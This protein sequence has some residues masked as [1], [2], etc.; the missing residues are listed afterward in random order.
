MDRSR[1]DTVGEPRVRTTGSATAMAAAGAAAVALAF[2]SGAMPVQAAAA[3]AAW[4]VKPVRLVVGQ[5]IGSALDNAVRVIAPALGEALGQPVLLDNRPGAGGMV[6]MQVALAATPDGYTLVN[7]GSPQM[8]APLLFRKLSY[9][10][11]RD[12]IPVARLSVTQNVLVV[13]TAVPVTD[14]RG[15]VEWLRAR[16][17]QSNMASAGVGSASH[18][19]GMLF[20]TMTGSDALHVP[21]KGGA[22]AINAL[23]SNDAQYM[24]TPLAAA[25]GQVRGGKLRALAVA[26]EGRAPQLPDVP[27]LHEAGVKG[28]RGSGWNGLFAPRGTPAAVV[29]RA[30]AAS[31]AVLSRPQIQERML[32]AGVEAGTLVDPDFTRFMKDEAVRFATAARAAGLRPE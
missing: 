22:A 4:P 23:L 13:P 26:G 10:F 5:E 15:L 3:D 29:A 1:M 8:I 30:A 18:L 25:L 14:V 2:G 17:G 21:Y 19:A 6:A 16:P 9:D 11:F 12:F 28:Y 32:A 7:A 31:V 27:T 20:N 24:I